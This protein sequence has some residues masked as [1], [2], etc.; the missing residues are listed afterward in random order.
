MQSLER[1]IANMKTIVGVVAA[2]VLMLVL[3]VAPMAA[4]TWPQRTVKFILPLGPGSGADIGARLI[5]EKLAARWGQPVV[6]EN[7]PGGD[8]IVAINAFVAARDDHVLLLS[9]SSAFIAHPYVYDKLSYD[10]RDLSPVARISSTL[11]SIS[12]PP[13]LNVS[14]LNEVF[15]MARAQPGKLNWAS[16]TGATDL[17]LQSHIKKSSLDMVRVPYRNPVEALTDTMNGRVHVYWAAHAIVQAQAEAGKVKVVAITNSEPTSLLP[18]V[19]T[20]TQIGLPD[21]TLDGLIGIFGTRDL[22][23]S[24]RERISAD[25]K[26]ALADPA[27]HSR[28]TATGQIVVPGSGA[29][30]AASIDK[31]RAAMLEVAKALGIKEA[32]Q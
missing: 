26:A 9:P 17:I 4:Q 10:P 32:T 8:G 6:V 22:P 11:I 30:L 25:V 20:V 21:L 16:T 18:G 15:A 27:I 24:V 14:S 7:R 1:V 28:L 12:V 31:Q 29:E 2:S 3:S 23:Q 5:A 19:P 13:S